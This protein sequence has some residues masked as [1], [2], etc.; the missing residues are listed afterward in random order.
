MR[1]GVLDQRSR[2]F[3]VTIV[4]VNLWETRSVPAR[5]R[6]TRQKKMTEV[7]TEEQVWKEAVEARPGGSSL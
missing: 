1:S 2:L 5:N 4:Q 3:P 6:S 7:R